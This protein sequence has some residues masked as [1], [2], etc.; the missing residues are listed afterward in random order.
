M[1]RRASNPAL[2]LAALL[3][4][5]SGAASQADDARPVAIQAASAS[6]RAELKRQILSS[7]VAPGLSVRALGERHPAFSIDDVLDTAE[8]IGGPRWVDQDVV[9]VR[10]QVPASRVVERIESIDPQTRDPRLTPADLVRLKREWKTRTFQA[11]GQ[12][13]PS[14]KIESILGTFQSP[15]WQRVPQAARVDAAGR[16]RGAAAGTIV[17]TTSNIRVGP[18]ET[19][20][21]SFAPGA[22]DK[23]RIW[24][25][26]MPATTVQLRDDRVVEIGLYVDREGLEQQLRAVV[27]DGSMSE[28]EKS[29]A[30]TAGV[31]ALP[32]I[33]VGRASVETP[34]DDTSAAAPIRLRGLPAWAS[35]PLVAEGSSSAGESR[36]R[37]ARLAE[38]IAK[39]QLRAAIDKLL[40]TPDLTLKQA[41]A[42][43]PRV[44]DAIDRAVD[45][46]RVYQVDYNAD[47]SATV[48]V[49]LD[50]NELI[51]EL[52]SPR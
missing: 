15:A 52:T 45:N 33:V 46:A 35:D 23:L 39:D 20:D 1:N 5:A 43:N 48:R 7:S 36:L 3:M 31:R 21:Q 22:Q 37:T 25:Y 42:S 14:A 40:I 9:Q 30:L 41:A 51:D 19:I 44:A 50:P 47:G 6:A 2:C 8:Q 18:S 4:A 10:L 12:A 13:I 27:T 26:T 49:T 38:R 16:A 29:E 28:S 11:T 34:A 32:T 24:A 17:S